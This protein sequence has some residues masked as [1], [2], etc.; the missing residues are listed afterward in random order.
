[1]TLFQIEEL[2]SY[3]VQ[4]PP[5]HLLVA[6]YLGRGKGHDSAPPLNPT[7]RGQ[8]PSLDISSMLADLGPGFVGGDVHAGLSPV[9]LDVAELR[10]GAAVSD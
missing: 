10:H 1:M 7:R 6:G 3:W 4:H 5:L 9:V 2:T 8:R